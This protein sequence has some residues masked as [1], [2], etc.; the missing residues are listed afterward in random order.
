MQ[1]RLILHSG[2]HLFVTSMC[3]ATTE[4]ALAYTKIQDLEPNTLSSSTKYVELWGKCQFHVLTDNFYVISSVSSY[5]CGIFFAGRG[6]NS[7]PRQKIYIIPKRFDTVCSEGLNEPRNFCYKLV[8]NQVLGP[9]QCFFKINQLKK[10]NNF[11]KKNQNLPKLLLLRK[12]FVKP[13][14]YLFFQV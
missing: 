10:I 5:R 2:I 1:S 7:R 8:S 12:A 4:D 14:S 9:V 13:R 11:E 3:M 6:E